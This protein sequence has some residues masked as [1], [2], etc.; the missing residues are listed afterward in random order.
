[1]EGKGGCDRV[2][3]G[4]LRGRPHHLLWKACVGATGCDV[5]QLVAEVSAHAEFREPP[6]M[7]EWLGLS[8]S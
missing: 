8:S 7:A 2:R 3:P 5:V 4:S 1:M 6:N